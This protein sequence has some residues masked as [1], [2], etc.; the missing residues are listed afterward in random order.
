MAAVIGVAGMPRMRRMSRVV[1]AVYCN[2]RAALLHSLP[3]V[4][5]AGSM[6]YMLLVVIMLGHNF[7]SFPYP[8]GRGYTNDYRLASQNVP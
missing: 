3:A 6:M 7:G 1:A 8:P 5:V 4:M 2:F